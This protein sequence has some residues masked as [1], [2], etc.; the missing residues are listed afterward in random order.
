[1]LCPAPAGCHDTAVTFMMQ[2]IILMMISS[3]LQATADDNLLQ[4]QEYGPTVCRKRRL[5]RSNRQT[6]SICVGRNPADPILA[7][8]H[9]CIGREDPDPRYSV[10]TRLQ[11]KEQDE[12]F[13]YRYSF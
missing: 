9:G 6:P 7:Q 12:P 4:R 10:A 2:T 1:M 5:Q 8:V 3:C 11:S 13:N